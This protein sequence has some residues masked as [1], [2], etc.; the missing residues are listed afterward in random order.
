MLLTILYE[1]YTNIQSKR[2]ALRFVREHQLRKTLKKKEGVHS[3]EANYGTE[4]AKITYD[5]EKTSP[6][7]L[8]EALK[9]LGYSLIIPTAD[10]MGMSE[11][12]HAAHLG[13]TQSKQ[14]KLAELRD[15]RTKV[16]TAIPLAI[17][18]GFVMAW[19]VLSQF[20]ILPAVP[21][22]WSEFFHHVLPLMATYMLFVVGKPYLQGFYRFCAIRKSEHGYAYRYRYI[23]RVCLQ[24]NH[25]GISR[26]ASSVHQC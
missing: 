9:P 13:L 7:H 24:C 11:G 2:N 19:E 17:F 10:A 25:H 16:I 22:I 8:S 1:P 15:M 18:S 23:S 26:V 21:Y 3:V 20:N 4:A 6:E 14:E 5:S 12:D